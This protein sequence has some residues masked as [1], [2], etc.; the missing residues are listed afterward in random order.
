VTP[1]DVLRMATVEGA[2][3]AGMADRV[4]SLGVG[5]HADLVVLR[6]ND[7]NLVGTH[8]PVA[9]VVTAAHPGN[10]EKVFVGGVEARCQD[11]AGSVRTAAAS[12]VSRLS[13][14]APTR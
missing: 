11:V 5:K 13:A 6:A 12:L 7:I 9:A 3:A 14:S 2:A 1:A 8:D 10:V 4:G